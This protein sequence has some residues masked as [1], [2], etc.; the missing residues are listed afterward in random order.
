MKRRLFKF[1]SVFVVISVI[2]SVAAV[3]A[4]ARAS[5]YI[6]TYSASISRSGTTVTVNYA[7]IGTGS[8]TSIG[9]SSIVIYRN[10]VSVATFSYPTVSALRSSNT[11]THDSNVYYT[12]TS[13]NTYYA[14]ITFYAGNSS[15]SDTRTIT[16]SSVRL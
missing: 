1:I 2:C 6:E 5:D 3:S 12:G 11:F 15:G 10:G 4:A 7:I 13:G 9:A 16:T 8:M 14:V